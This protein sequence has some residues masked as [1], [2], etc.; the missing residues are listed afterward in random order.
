[1]AVS[2][3]AEITR[4]AVWIVSVPSAELRSSLEE[5]RAAGLDWRNRV[6][7][8]LDGEAE[9]E[10]ATAFRT[11]GAAVASFAPVDADASRYVVEGDADAIRAVR[12][13][14]GD[15]HQRLLVQIKKG[16]KANYLAGAQA[17]TTR[18]LPLIA[19]AIDNFQFAGMSNS[20]AKAITESL[21]SGSMRLYFRAGRRSLKS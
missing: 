11:A 17:A 3:I 7:L 4:A 13:L 21:L 19:E 12:L 20:E 16:A 10:G 5:L 8:I 14:L 6:L 18:V 1:V 15:S 2:D 9:S